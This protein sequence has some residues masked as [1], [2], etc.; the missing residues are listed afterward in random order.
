[1][2]G[3]SRFDS[4]PRDSGI[5]LIFFVAILLF[6]QVAATLLLPKGQDPNTPNIYLVTAT[7]IIQLVLAGL[8]TLGFLANRSRSQGTLRVFWGLFA[9]S[10]ATLTFNQAV[11]FSYEVLLRRSPPN[12]F[13]GDLLLFLG[14]T[15]ILAALIL[16][17]QPQRWKGRQETGFVDFALLLV[18]WLY[19]YLYFVAPWQF[20]EINESHY[21]SYYNHLDAVGD[22]AVLILTLYLFKRASSSWR[23]FY[24]AFFASQ[25][26]LSGSSYLTNSAIE[27]NAYSTGS[28]YDIPFST[29]LGLFT[30]VA[31]MG[32]S[33][34]NDVN[35][36]HTEHAFPLSRWGMF[37]LLSLPFI[38]GVTAITQDVS[39]P[40]RRFRELVVQCSILAM[41]LLIFMRQRRLMD[42][43]AES[44]R[45]LEQASIT[46]SLTGCH[47]RRFLDA[48]LPV[49]ASRALRLSQ[50]APEGRSNDLVFFLIDLDDFKQV[51]DRHG[52]GMGDRVLVAIANRIKSVIRKSDVLVR[53][54]GDEFLVLS[55]NFD[56]DEASRFCGRI[57][58]VIEAPIT[59]GSS[60]S[61][62]IHQ[63]CSIGWAAYPWTSSRPDELEFEAV[64]GL[65]D[66][67][68]YRAKS[69]G[70]N[71]GVGIM[72]SGSGNVIFETTPT[73]H[74][75]SH[76]PR[77]TQLQQEIDLET[78]GNLSVATS[79]SQQLDERV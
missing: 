74:D 79:S 47:N 65:A 75:S 29:A 46:D 3:K 52:H 71:Q 70:K 73:T 13:L 24:G 34:R 56:R 57:L 68:L 58:D 33:L 6:L 19:L 5:F 18:W 8:A 27:S 53:W 49:E 26:L 16:R 15:P 42:E 25:L 50:T 60:K 37:S 67:A 4:K 21:N 78:L 43:L 48:A 11:W 69:S 51:N 28:W 31:L 17:T 1:M 59:T 77:G 66:Q 55:C 30:I 32:S 23:R 2:P 62:S 45:I 39:L 10:W 35:E 22:A 36:M 14:A 9:A 76:P 38:T 63:T 72:P 61:P 40:V 44:S 64:L 7:D 41:G 20:V 54:G 12:P